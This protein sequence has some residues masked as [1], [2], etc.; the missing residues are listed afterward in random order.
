MRFLASLDSFG[1]H[2]VGH[3]DFPVISGTFIGCNLGGGTGVL[4][5][6]GSELKHVLLRVG[7]EVDAVL[8][9]QRGER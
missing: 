9:S 3:I 1:T 5:T 2:K 4:G 7:V 6:V 8:L